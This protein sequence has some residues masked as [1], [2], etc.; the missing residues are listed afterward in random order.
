MISLQETTGNVS[1]LNVGR[2]SVKLES[3]S[4]QFELRIIDDKR[5]TK[6]EY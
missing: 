5:K 2:C 4:F 1:S 6:K 3:L